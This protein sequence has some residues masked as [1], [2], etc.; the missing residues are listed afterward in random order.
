M[1]QNT[2]HPPLDTSCYWVHVSPHI[3]TF[4][5]VNVDMY[6][7]VCEDRGHLGCHSIGTT[8]VVF[9]TGLLSW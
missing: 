9:E 5:Q 7:H 2:R 1:E 8:H 3:Q 6:A 4:V